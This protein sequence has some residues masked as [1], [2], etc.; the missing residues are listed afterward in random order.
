MNRTE[1]KKFL[2]EETVVRVCKPEVR[3]FHMINEIMK[4]QGVELQE[5]SFSFEQFIK[6]YIF[7]NLQG[8]EFI[9]CCKNLRNES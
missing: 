3:T 1:S 5:S 7:N 2:G 6:D 9:N 8:D 4:F